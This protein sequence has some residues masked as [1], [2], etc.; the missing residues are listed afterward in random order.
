MKVARNCENSHLPKSFR[1]W[2]GGRVSSRRLLSGKTALVGNESRFCRSKRPRDQSF[3]EEFSDMGWV[4]VS[5][6]RQVVGHPSWSQTD[7]LLLHFA[8]VHGLVI[9]IRF[10]S[11]LDQNPVFPAVSLEL[12]THSKWLKSAWNA[13]KTRFRQFS[14]EGPRGRWASRLRRPPLRGRQPSLVGKACP[15]PPNRFHPVR[16]CTT[17]W[18][19]YVQKIAMLKE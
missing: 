6:R 18:N 10:G 4:G 17:L 5:S 15:C 11:S 1:K 7:S 14:A 13:W 19:I 16:L 9:T 8:V 12:P 2:G 3:T